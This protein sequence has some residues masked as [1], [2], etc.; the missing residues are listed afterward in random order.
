MKLYWL[1]K[2]DCGGSIWDSLGYVY[3]R[4]VKIGKHGFSF[5]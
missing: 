3:M 2:D 4:G 5:V 1:M